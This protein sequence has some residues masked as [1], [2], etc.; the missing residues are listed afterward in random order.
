[1]LY[2]MCNRTCGWMGSTVGAVLTVGMGG[3]AC[4]HQI[5]PT[6]AFRIQ[7]RLW[8]RRVCSRSAPHQSWTT[9]PRLCSSCTRT[10]KNPQTPPIA[11]LLACA[12]VLVQ[13]TGRNFWRKE[14]QRMSTDVLHRMHV[15]K[16]RWV[17][18]VTA[19]TLYCLRDQTY[20]CCRHQ[21]RKNHS[22]KLRVPYNWLTCRRSTITKWNHYLTTRGHMVVGGPSL[23][24]Q[25]CHP[26]E[27]SVQEEDLNQRPEPSLGHMVVGGPSLWAQGC[28]PAESS[29][30][31]EDLNQRPEPSLS[32][33]SAQMMMTIPPLC[34]TH[35][36]WVQP[37]PVVAC[38]N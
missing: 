36:S 4:M 38:M 32:Q 17:S 24:A 37:H 25:G 26:A 22:E 2:C 13:N 35:H 23:W 1:M 9:W 14:S 16:H 11:T 7:R 5:M 12:S 29:V 28:H 8:G 19:T 18:L 15:T 34:C 10:P 30:Q 3:A 27:S 6:P 31:E 21:W 33:T 20:P